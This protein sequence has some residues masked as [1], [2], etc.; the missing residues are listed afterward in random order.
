MRILGIHDGHNSSASLVVDGKV[1]YCIQE[2]RLTNEKNFWDFPEKSVRKI[3]D[4][5][6]LTPADIDFVAVASLHAPRPSDIIEDYKKCASAFTNTVNSILMKTPLYKYYRKKRKEE[7]LADITKLGFKKS[8]ISFIDHHLCHASAAYYGCPC[9]DE[10]ILVFTS[11]GSGDGLCGS[12]CIG[13]KGE[14]K[15][16]AEVPKGNS[17]GNV[18]SN[19][20]FMLG[21]VPWEHEWKIMGM[22]P[23]AYEKDMK[24]SYEVFSKYM[25]LDKENLSFVRHIPEATNY[26]YSRL[27]KDFEF[28]RFDW[29]S[30][31]VQEFTEE[32]LVD[33]VREASR[34]TGI[35]KVC[36]SG[37]V[38][39]NVKANKRIME[40]DEVD[41]IFPFPSAGDE[42]NS[43]GAAYYLYN[44]K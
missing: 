8:S 20:T 42:S 19:V 3:L 13:E 32:L 27:R 30:A 9:R 28:H 7:R 35:R 16:I 26:I 1:K 33:W 12:V 10:K 4:L 18:Y 15:K 11:D 37:G 43:I 36:M 23:Y 6:K 25:E 2:E 21:L 41:D 14:L 29:I 17:I 31:G 24:K 38:F 44:K 34:K 5:E 39:M 22:A 40:L